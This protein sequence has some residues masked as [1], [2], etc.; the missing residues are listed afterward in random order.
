MKVKYEQ[1]SKWV[2]IVRPT[3]EKQWDA[4]YDA[5]A[6]VKAEQIKNDEVRFKMATSWL[7]EIQAQKEEEV[8][9]AKDAAAA[10]ERAKG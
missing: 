7:D 9:A 1:R 5:M 4:Y 2:T 3:T 8:E 6:L 10:A